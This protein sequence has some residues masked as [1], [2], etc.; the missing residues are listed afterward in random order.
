MVRPSGDAVLIRYTGQKAGDIPYKSIVDQRTTYRFST[1]RPESYVHRE[2][3]DKL[4]GYD[5][6]EL[7]AE[8]PA[9]QAAGEEAPLVAARI[10]VGVAAGGMD[11]TWA[12]ETG[13]IG[14]MPGLG[15][16]LSQDEVDAV[17]IAE[18]PAPT[19]TIAMPP[20]GTPTE[21]AV[22]MP[23]EPAPEASPEDE[24]AVAAQ[25]SP[26]AQA[27]AARSTRE[28]LNAE[29]RELGIEGIEAVKTKA[30][31]AQQIVIFRKMFHR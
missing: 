26:E 6:F 28:A 3:A 30:E 24:A 17:A 20:T 10:P 27:L 1:N 12:A 21:T 2:D 4:L 5:D 31:V 8:H 16:I 25:V 7:V 22:A 23:T 14:T 11:G 18:R 15:I 19:A 29:A 9:V 13:G